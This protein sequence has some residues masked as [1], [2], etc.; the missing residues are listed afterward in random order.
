MSP[1]ADAPWIF[2]ITDNL[3]PSGKLDDLNY[4]ATVE[5]QWVRLKYDKK[6]DLL[7]F[8]DFEKLPDRPFTFRLQVKDFCGNL[9]EKL[10]VIN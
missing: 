3:I 7:L 8:D 1:K 10:R 5:G 4:R 9:S 6:K 2:K